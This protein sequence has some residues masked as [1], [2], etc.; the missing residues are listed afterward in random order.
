MASFTL[1]ICI[2]SVFEWA[3]EICSNRK[4]RKVK[5]RTLDPEGCGTLV[6][7]VCE[8]SAYIDF[9]FA[10]FGQNLFATPKRR[11]N[12]GSKDP[13]LQRKRKEGRIASHPWEC[14]VDR[15]EAGWRGLTKGEKE[16][17]RTKVPPLHKHKSTTQSTNRKAHRKAQYKSGKEK[18]AVVSGK[19]AGTQSTRK[20][21]RYA[22]VRPGKKR[23]GLKSGPYT[24]TKARH[25][26]TNRKGQ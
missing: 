14:Q 8:F 15:G 16:R 2:C 7:L 18:V 13:P 22:N 17:E 21:W 1:S 10:D 24:N 11:R 4:E 9:T 23:G 20:G 12:H 19:T 6:E 3:V 26:G 25:E 5:N